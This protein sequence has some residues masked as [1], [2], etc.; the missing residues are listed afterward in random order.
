M[1]LLL[2]FIAVPLIEIGLFIQVGG[3]I[4]LWP[5]LGIVLLTACAG[6]MLVRQQGSRAL[7]ELRQS[8]GALSDPAMPLAE[9]AAILFAGALLLTPGFF[10][11]TLGLLLLTPPFRRWLLRRL[12]A[13]VTV[14]RFEMGG[15]PPR[16]PAPG[17][18]IDGEF[19]EVARDPQPIPAPGRKPPN[20]KH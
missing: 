2:V 12:A 11:D 16:N 20:P 15:G 9:G 14:A 18:V 1:W 19:H 10:T 6:A 4:G 7:A 3:W 8:F 5:T 17:D 13:R